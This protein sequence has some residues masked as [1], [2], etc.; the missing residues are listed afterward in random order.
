MQGDD[1]TGAGLAGSDVSGAAPAAGGLSGGGPRSEDTSGG[2]ATW[3]RPPVLRMC[4]SLDADLDALATSP[5][6]A[7][8]PDEQAEA[9]VAL[10]RQRARLKELEL[11]CLVAADRNQVGAD[12]G[13]TSTP[14]WL[15]DRTASTRAACFRDLRLAEQLDEDF[16]R[17]RR[18]LAAGVIDAEKAAVIVSA[19]TALTDEHDDL[20]ADTHER[21]EEH[22]LAL[23]VR[24]DPREL[25]RLGKRLYE[26]VCPEG[27]DAAEGRKLEAEEKRARRLAYLTIRDNGDGT[28]EGRLRLPTLH[29]H[30]LKKALEVLTSPRVLGEGRIDP[31]TGKKFEHST[32]LGHGF[33]D[34]LENRLDLDAMPSSHDAPFTLTIHVDLQALE[35][36]IG[37]AAVETGH[38]ISAGEARRLACKAGIIPMVLDGASV[39]VDLGRERRL[40]S[41][42]QKLA[43]DH[44]YGGCA[45]A[46][47]DR[48]PS[49][50]EYHHLDPWHRDGRTDLSK[51]LP[52]C[53][54][55]HHMADHPDAWNMRRLPSGGVRFTRRT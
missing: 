22:L 34:L 6:W 16:D 55:H 37:V 23:A 15:A 27:A 42:Q 24:F 8:S 5:A 29:A 46:N 20:P 36:G 2:A 26:V 30:L 35:S 4:D 51:G 45:A 38:R 40:F 21:A 17:T 7:L 3:D 9:V 12:S 11:R 48:P 31:E 41:K 14:A 50:V 52:L 19:V 25:R 32:L 1:A 53:P 18:A 33:M 47:C 54:P 13:A 39:P 44:V 28:S 49:W 43:L 10:R